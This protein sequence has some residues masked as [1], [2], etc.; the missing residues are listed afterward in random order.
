MKKSHATKLWLL[1]IFYASCYIALVVSLIVQVSQCIKKFTDGSTY[2][3][4]SVVRQKITLFPDIT[5]CGNM[6]GLKEAK[7]KVK[8]FS[9]WVTGTFFMDIGLSLSLYSFVSITLTVILIARNMAQLSTNTENQANKPAGQA[10]FQM[11][12]FKKSG[13]R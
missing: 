6:F 12:Q 2:Y 5:V 3:D 7:L 4:S 11:F 8:I 9:Q 10:N 1:Q 13:M